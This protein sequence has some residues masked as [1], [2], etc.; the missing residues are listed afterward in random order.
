MIINLSFIYCMIPFQKE[1]VATESTLIIYDRII[2]FRYLFLVFL[3]WGIQAN[4][5]SFH[6]FEINPDRLFVLSITCFLPGLGFFLWPDVIVV[7]E[8]KEQKLHIIRRSIL[9]RFQREIN[10]SDI[11]NI[12]VCSS[13]T[14][15]DPYTSS[16][17][18]RIEL[19]LKK[20][21]DEIPFRRFSTHGIDRKQRTVDL[22]NEFIGLK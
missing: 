12:Y 22:L 5:E 20:S 11:K 14:W 2:L 19:V 21:L 16:K 13:S 6:N 9:F 15:S 3:I 17:T 1:E 10:F 4:L 8:K 7:A 18:Y